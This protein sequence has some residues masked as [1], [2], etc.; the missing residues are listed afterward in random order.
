M[1]RLPRLPFILVATLAGQ[2]AAQRPPASDGETYRLAADSR[3]EIH[4][5]RAGLLAAAGHEHLIRARVFEGSI[6]YRPDDPTHAAVTVAVA[7][8]DLY[9]VPAADSADIPKI[10]ATMRNVVL[11]VDA[12]PVIRF[13]SSAVVPADRGVHVEGTLTMMGL[14]RPVGFDA[15]LQ[16]S[17]DTLTGT[18]T[19]SVRQSDFGIHPYST[20]LGLVRVADL[21]RFEIRLR[22]T[23][24]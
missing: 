7:T 15:E 14:A 17:G 1:T 22:G 4:V 8:R 16:L 10:T 19:F 6:T 13:V 21:V 3:L 9:V 18:A 20:A 23:R 12:N 2:A 5:A 11:K 24:H